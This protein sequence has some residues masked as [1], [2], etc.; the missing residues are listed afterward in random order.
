[1]YHQ[2]GEVIMLGS[3]DGQEFSAVRQGYELRT[4]PRAHGEM[5][6]TALGEYA[7][8][9]EQNEADAPSRL[10]S[11]TEWVAQTKPDADPECL[12]HWETAEQ[13]RTRAGEGSFLPSH[14]DLLDASLFREERV[15][16][17]DTKLKI[18]NKKELR[19][20]LEAG[21]IPLSKWPGARLHDLY[22]YT[23]AN[24]PDRT[25]QKVEN[26]TLHDVRGVLWLA[27]AQT[28]LNVYHQSREGFIYKL[29]ET[30]KTIYDS[31]GTPQKPVRSKLNSSMG[32]T[33]HLIGDTTERAW[34]TARRCLLEELSIE[35]DEII[36]RIVSSGSLL[37]HKPAGHH[38]FGPIAAEDRTHYFD[39][40]LAAEHVEPAYVNKEYDADGNLRASIV[41]E[42]SKHTGKLPATLRPRQ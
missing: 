39:V 27:T 1:M 14:M 6:F 28:M 2:S 30:W 8:C 20:L 38:Q 3:I 31:K 5:V 34:A 21:N 32:E 41:L 22:N 23:Q 7:I 29:H 11:G 37:R 26:M 13:L 10:V 9:E 4:S 17:A 12:Y 42:W 25:E 33:G 36:K 19:R 35:D 16:S 18:T 40:E 24:N 15:T